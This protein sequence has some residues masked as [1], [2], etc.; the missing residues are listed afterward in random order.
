[1]QYILKIFV[2]AISFSLFSCN[3]DKKVKDTSSEIKSEDKLL[4]DSETTTFNILSGAELN[5]WLPEKI[6]E[7]VKEPTS[8]ELGEDDLHQVKATYQYKS[9]HEKYITVEITNGRSAKDLN[10]KDNILQGVNT[11]YAEDTESGHTKAYTRKNVKVFERQSL[12]NNTCS[13]DYLINNRFYVKL[14]GS[15][16]KVEELWQ[17]AD[18]LNFNQLN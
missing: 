4:V 14:D 16:M 1:M 9:G 7:Y 3:E 5:E 6:L 17:F 13:L 11:K 18:Q 15:N 10:V 12:Y 8:L 2:F